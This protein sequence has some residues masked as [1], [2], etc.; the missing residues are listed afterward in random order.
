V[1]DTETLDAMKR[2]VNNCALAKEVDKVLA[3][4]A[5]P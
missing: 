3:P 5:S 1:T 2:Q 4:A